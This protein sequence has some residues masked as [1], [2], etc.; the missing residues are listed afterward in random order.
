MKKFLKNY[1]TLLLKYTFSIVFIIMGYSIK[2]NGN[3]LIFSLIELAL[4]FAISDFLISKSKWFNV[5]NAALIL[6]F[7]AENCVLFF[8]NSYISNVMLDNLDNLQDLEGRATMYIAGV[9]LVIIFS[10]LPI[11]N[12]KSHAVHIGRTIP[13]LA[14]L[15]CMIL[16]CYN[17]AYTP[18]M[19]ARDLHNQ[20][21]ERQM[22]KDMIAKYRE[23]MDNED[24]K[25]ITI[26]E[27]RQKSASR[28]V[29]EH[30]TKSQDANVKKHVE[31]EEEFLDRLSR[32]HPLGAEVPHAVYGSDINILVI[33][34]EGL[35]YNV[36][37]DS[38]NIMPNAA[39]LRDNSISFDNYYNHTFATFRGIQGQ[40]YS[41]FTYEDTDKITLTSMMDILRGNGY[42]CAFLNTEPLHAT[43]TPYLN[44]MSFDGVLS[45]ASILNGPASSISDKDAYQKLFEQAMIYNEEGRKFFLATYTFGTHATFDTV[46]EIYGDGSSPMLNK[47]YNADYQ[48]GVFL[49][50]FLNS[51]LASN[52]MLVFTADHA[53]YADQE[54]VNTFPKRTRVDG[55]CDEIPLFIYYQGKAG[56]IDAN[57][58]NSLDFAPTILD[59]LGLEA[60]EDFLGQSL[61]A[62]KNEKTIVD[63][64]FW[65]FGGGVYYTGDDSVKRI[66][67]KT[68]DYVYNLIV[69]YLARNGY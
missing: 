60:S 9:A 66:D 51:P 2:K 6:L 40:L 34:T 24:N 11:K 15:E 19:G 42:Y 14:L 21:K 38:R 53:T 23:N 4:I 44:A 29:N 35:S 61:F 36:I 28:P 1:L 48:L 10:F 32:E 46:D 54:F 39:M 30:K 59:L 57:G 22:I 55:G 68:E 43:F 26:E 5:I 37:T 56:R 63:T 67:K 16:I 52:T 12:V 3:Y 13:A 65:N 33:F 25:P 62:A 20:Y 47:F 27:A 58:R 17:T 69:A 64:F 18:L 8:G 7:N 50:E 49:Q 31:T 41:G 45:D